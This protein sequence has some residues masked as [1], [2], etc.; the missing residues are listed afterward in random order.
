MDDNQ[1]SFSFTDE[2]RNISFNFSVETW[3]EALEEFV[4]LIGAAYG[5]NIKDQV[6]IK[7]SP[8]LNS[9]NEWTGPVFDEE[10]F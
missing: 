5:Y 8:F 3:P 6:A 4:S 10:A 1:F 2:K 7:K 9:S